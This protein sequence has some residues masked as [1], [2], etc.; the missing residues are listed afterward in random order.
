MGHPSEQELAADVA[1][2]QAID[3]VDAILRD[4][5]RL[6]GMRFAA[7]AR[8]TSDR[9][10]ACQV[11]DRIEFG[12]NPGDE[13]KISTTICDEIRQSGVAVIIDDV[14]ADPAWASHRTPALYGF[15]SY[16]SLPIVLA[17]G[18]FFG[19][20]CAIDPDARAAKL[21]DVVAAIMAHAATIAAALDQRAIG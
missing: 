3:G 20:L 11:L 18:S 17:D 2:V 6:T 5:C 15:R 19:T 4:V 21:A 1:I 8:V 14:N 12:L 16:L 10:I 13:L 9:W 7:V